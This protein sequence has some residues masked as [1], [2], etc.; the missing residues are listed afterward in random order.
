MKGGRDRWF[1]GQEEGEN[2]KEGGFCKDA[3]TVRTVSSSQSRRA[4]PI[5]GPAMGVRL[6]MVKVNEGSDS[7]GGD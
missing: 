5:C 4:V 6:S 2:K 3:A 7:G 1:G